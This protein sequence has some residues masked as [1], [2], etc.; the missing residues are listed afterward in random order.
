MPVVDT[1]IAP[2][3]APFHNHITLDQKSA[4]LKPSLQPLSIIFL[5]K[6]LGVIASFWHLFNQ[7]NEIELER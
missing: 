7:A 2:L 1:V 5:K 6:G 3:I 4:T